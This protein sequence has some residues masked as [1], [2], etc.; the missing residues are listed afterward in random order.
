MAWKFKPEVVKDGFYEGYVLVN[1]PGYQE[2][3]QLLK[4]VNFDFDQEKG[5]I[6]TKKALEL[7]D[8]MAKIA[9]DK[10]VEVKLKRVECGT[11]TKTVDELDQNPE[12]STVID[13]VASFVLN[14]VRLSKN[15]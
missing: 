5:A 9:I 11:E 3:N 8:Q 12:L 6:P 10:I 1:F 13:E 7:K 4:S 15:L 2:R 14:G